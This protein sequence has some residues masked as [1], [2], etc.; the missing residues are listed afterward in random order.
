MK[1]R[2]HLNAPGDFYVENGIC[3]GNWCRLRFEFVNIRRFG[4]EQDR[5]FD[6]NGLSAR[7]MQESTQRP[8]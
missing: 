8:A 1:E 6:V 7:F 5:G 2:Y 3:I 4:W